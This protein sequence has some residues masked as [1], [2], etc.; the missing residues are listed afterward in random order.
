MFAGLLRHR[1]FRR[2]NIIY[3]LG[4]LSA[5]LLLRAL[6]GE[7]ESLWTVMVWMICIHTPLL[8]ALWFSAEWRNCAET[9]KKQKEWEVTTAQQEVH[10]AQ[11]LLL[12]SQLS[13]HTLFNSLNGIAQLVHESSPNAEKSIILLAYYYQGI[14]GASEKEKSTLREER[15]LMEQYLQFEMLRLEDR[16]LVEWEW[17]DSLNNVKLPPLLFQPLVENAIKHGIARNSKGGV[18][19][20]I[21]EQTETGIRLATLNTHGTPN[22]ISA[23]AFV[24]PLDKGTRNLK[25]R[26]DIAFGRQALYKIFADEEWTTAEIHIPREALA[27]D[28]ATEGSEVRPLKARKLEC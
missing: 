2:E 11:T 9:H 16:L 24:E 15:I 27:Q 10:I 13:P 25:A 19:R 21:L 17:D 7:R 20:I 1:Y 22:T 5:V 4:F 14:L 8:A 28:K 12:Q 3:P 6:L 18:V 26:L 23:P